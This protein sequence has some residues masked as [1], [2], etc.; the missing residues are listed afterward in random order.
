MSNL[1][2]A[3]GWAVVDLL[4]HPHQLRL[5]ADG[6]RELSQRCALESTRLAQ[7]SIMARAVLEPVAFDT[8]AGGARHR[9]SAVGH[10]SATG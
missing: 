10:R 6:D 1:M 5:V 4:V 8:G 3:L 7:R 2:A 9:R